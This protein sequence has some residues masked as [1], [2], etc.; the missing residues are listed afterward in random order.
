MPFQRSRNNNINEVVTSVSMFS[1]GAYARRKSPS[2]SFVIILK[3]AQCQLCHYSPVATKYRGAK[4]K[5]ILI[6]WSDL[7]KVGP[8]RTNN[9][10]HI[11]LN[12]VPYNT[13]VNI[14]S[15]M[16]YIDKK[17]NSMC[18][19]VSSLFSNTCIIFIMKKDNLLIQL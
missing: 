8:I 16:F 14:L 12:W 11:T 17:T 9:V 6:F 3:Q 19:Y 7:Y 18:Y 1:V 15:Q 13:I 2:V 10:K 4:Q 5:P